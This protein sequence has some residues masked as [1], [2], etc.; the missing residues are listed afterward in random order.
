[1]TEHH[2]ITKDHAHAGYSAAHEPVLTVDPGTG[3]RIAFETD[4]AAYAQMEELEPVE[5]HGDD[6]PRHRSGPRPG[7]QAVGDAL[8]VTIRGIDMA[9]GRAGRSTC[10]SGRAGPGDG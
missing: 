4:D 8:A 3:E 10:R 2:L 1:M 9:G 5:G 6:Q 7:S